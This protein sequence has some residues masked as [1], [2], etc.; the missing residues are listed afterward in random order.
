MVSSFLFLFPIVFH[1]TFCN[2]SV[3][4]KTFD[5]EI[6][7]AQP[8]GPKSFLALFLMM[9]EENHLKIGITYFFLGSR[10][11]DRFLARLV[12]LLDIKMINQIALCSEHALA[13][14][15]SFV[16]FQTLNFTFLAGIITYSSQ[17][18]SFTFILLTFFIFY[19][20]NVLI[21]FNY[22]YK[23]C[24][25]SVVAPITMSTRVFNQKVCFLQPRGPY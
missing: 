12:F 9:L 22:Y 20:I 21:L 13:Q 10:K 15:F 23:K 7:F 25:H 24:Y 11:Q 17:S 18:V 19:F 2:P 14:F 16:F 5:D 8:C 6:F 4:Q 1:Y 3:I